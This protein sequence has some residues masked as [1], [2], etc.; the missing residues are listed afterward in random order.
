MLARNGL[1]K[2]IVQ[3]DIEDT[4]NASSIEFLLASSG[5]TSI[6]DLIQNFIR[7]ELI[8]EQHIFETSSFLDQKNC[9]ESLDVNQ[10][11]LKFI[12]QQSVIKQSQEFRE[13]HFLF[14]NS[15]RT[16][17]S[18]L[19]QNFIRN[20]LIYE[21]HI[22][23]T[24]SFLD[25]KNCFELLDVNQRNLKF[26]E[27]QSVI[28][29]SQEFREQQFINILRDDVI[30][31]GEIPNAELYVKDL[32]R[33]IGVEDTLLLLLG[34][35]PNYYDDPKILCGILHIISHFP[36]ETLGKTALLFPT[37]LFSHKDDSVVEYAVKT[38]ENWHT[39]EALKILNNTELRIHWLQKY[40]ENVKEELE[41]GE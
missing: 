24:S 3:S 38:M 18:D 26:I 14:A 9:F 40:I 27:Q 12:E 36:Y 30:E 20:E 22:F 33:E 8:Y 19:I 28:K 21:Q 10:R 29:Q 31:A 13:Q 25:Q 34:M 6:S 4:K 35:Y 16:S 32:F 17:I 11:N 5:R 37:A 2:Q 39:K 41:R 7:N 23:E 15:G 1:D